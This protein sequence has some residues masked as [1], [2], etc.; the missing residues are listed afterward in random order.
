MVHLTNHQQKHNEKSLHQCPLCSFSTNAPTSLGKHLAWDHKKVKPVNPAIDEVA[1]AVETQPSLEEEQD[2]LVNMTLPDSND[3]G[4]GSSLQEAKAATDESRH[5]CDSCDYSTRSSSR[6]KRH[7]KKHNRI[8]KFLCPRCTFSA[9]KQSKID[10]HLKKDHRAASIIQEATEIQS[11]SKETTD[12]VAHDMVS[13][14]PLKKHV[15]PSCGL[16]VYSIEQESDMLNDPES[17]SCPLCTFSTVSQW[18]M[19]QHLE[20]DHLDATMN[21][22]D[23]IAQQPTTVSVEEIDNFLDKEKLQISAEATR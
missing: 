2:P 7:K 21:E 15:F 1:P 14:F 3:N 9:K 12:N 8:E 22:L 6:I 23:E 11:S 5:R 10:Q 13:F 16:L 17:R 18:D 20:R 19:D 4:N